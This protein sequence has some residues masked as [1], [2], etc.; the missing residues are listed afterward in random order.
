MHAGVMAC[1]LWMACGS[2]Y[3]G[4]VAGEKGPAAGAALAVQELGVR[5]VVADRGGD[6]RVFVAFGNTP[7]G[8]GD[9]PAGFL[10]RLT[11]TG[12]VFEPA[13][14][15]GEGTSSQPLLVVH[16]VRWESDAEAVVSV[17]RFRRGVGASDGFTAR[18]KWAA[19]VWR[20]EKRTASWST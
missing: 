1:G 3:T 17:T 6:H 4:E 9:P 20:L 19:G 7:E 2:Q 5:Y 14:E 10:E 15:L 11:D 12:V 16:D 8:R 18:V 13:S